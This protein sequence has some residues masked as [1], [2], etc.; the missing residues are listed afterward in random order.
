MAEVRKRI[1]AKKTREPLVRVQISKYWK[2]H[3][4]YFCITFV[5]PQ[6]NDPDKF[7]SVTVGLLIDAKVS[8]KIPFL[9]HPSTPVKTVHT[10]CE[11]CDIMDCK[12]RDA[13]PTVIEHLDKVELINKTLKE[14]NKA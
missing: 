12:E 13:Q 8:Q 9:N 2:T 6:S 11:R 7:V 14:L 4:N 3:N 1:A 10:T 5:K